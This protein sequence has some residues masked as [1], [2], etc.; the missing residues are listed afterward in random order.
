MRTHEKGS[1]GRRTQLAQQPT[2]AGRK[3]RRLGDDLPTPV[4]GHRQPDQRDRSPRDVAAALTY[5]NAD[6]RGDDEWIR[7]RGRPG[8]RSMW[9][10]ARRL[11]RAG[12]V[13]RGRAQKSAVSDGVFIEQVRSRANGDLT[14]IYRLSDR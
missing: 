6:R 12:S 9:G 3:A 4:A 2:I 13:R 11:L 14:V 8:K 7:G 5:D 1:A 10:R